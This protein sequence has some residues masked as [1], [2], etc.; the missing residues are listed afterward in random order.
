[1]LRS[2][3]GTATAA[4]ATAAVL[5]LLPSGPATAVERRD[6]FEGLTVHPEWGSVTGH[7]GVLRRGCK[8]YTYNYSI[9][10]PDGIWAL[11]VVI[12]G[13]RLESLGGGAFEESYDPEQGTVT[14]KL[15]R[16]T[17]T[18]GRFRIR[19]KLSVSDENSHHITA[20]GRLPDDYFRLRRPHRR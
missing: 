2:V 13:P 1:V 8:T 15:C 6:P 17:T 16:N 19:A 10:P 3:R 14:Y 20:E 11:E 4:A 5:T 9:D 12:S 18:Y 7:G